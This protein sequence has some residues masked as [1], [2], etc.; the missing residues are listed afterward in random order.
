MLHWDSLKI[1]CL[2]EEE[3]TGEMWA[4]NCISSSCYRTKLHQCVSRA[5]MSIRAGYTIDCKT[6]QVKN[7]RLSG[8]WKGR[9]WGLKQRVR[10]GVLCRK[11]S[12][13]RYGL[14]KPILRRKPTVLQSRYMKLV[15][16]EFFLVLY[17][18][19]L[20]GVMLKVASGKLLVT[21]PYWHPWSMCID[22]AYG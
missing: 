2:Q 12:Q 11:I 4:I 18:F 1:C 9:E 14:S 5:G 3:V 20:L 17:A 10:L 6:A 21:S 15:A 19:C 13:Q 16:G 8:Q 22:L 7:A